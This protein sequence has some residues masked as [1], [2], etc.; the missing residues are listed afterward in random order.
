LL[1]L[2]AVTLAVLLLT[3]AARQLLG[4]DFPN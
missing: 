2:F 3:A 1:L 4:A